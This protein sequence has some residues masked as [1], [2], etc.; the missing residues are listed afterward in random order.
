MLIVGDVFNEFLGI[1]EKFASSLVET[2]FSDSLNMIIKPS[3][4][5]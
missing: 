5:R 4:S 2:F 1:H 3:S